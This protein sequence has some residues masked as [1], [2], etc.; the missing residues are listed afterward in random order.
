MS[1][2]FIATTNNEDGLLYLITYQKLANVLKGMGHT[3]IRD[4][5]KI[6]DCDLAILMSKT[7]SKKI[8]KIC[9]DSK[10]PVILLPENISEYVKEN[11]NNNVSLKQLKLF[12]RADE[13]ICDTQ[14]EKDFLIKNGIIKPINL[15]QIIK[16]SRYK[17]NISS[18]EQEVINRV[19]RIPNK[20]IIV[21][22][23]GSFSVDEHIKKAN[24][25]ARTFPN[26]YFFFV[27]SKVK[28][29]N[30]DES[31]QKKSK[32]ENLKFIGYLRPEIYPSLIGN[33]SLFINLDSYFGNLALLSD[34]TV[35]DIPI[36]SANLVFFSDSLEKGKD[37]IVLDDEFSSFFSDVKFSLSDENQCVE[38][39]KAKLKGG[40]DEIQY[41]KLEDFLENISKKKEVQI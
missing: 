9:S 29:T 11:K 6:Q 36:I 13:I 26:W 16:P 37:Y 14:I 27:D 32:N 34:I 21:L 20:S 7:Y 18:L 17:N 15:I 38:N 31:L 30:F 22:L 12:N 5:K 28:Q 39:I 40:R 4:L 25:I 19:F 24:I 35:N 23:Y 2:I 33:T 8:C 1:N 10:I 41:K 3:I